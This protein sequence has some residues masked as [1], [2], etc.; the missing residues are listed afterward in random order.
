MT[1]AQKNLDAIESHQ[2]NRETLD[3][4]CYKAFYVASHNKVLLGT[5]LHCAPVCPRARRYRAEQSSA[6]LAG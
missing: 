2:K 6:Y 5:N 1:E 4:K 3:M